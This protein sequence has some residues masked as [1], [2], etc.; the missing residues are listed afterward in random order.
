MFKCTEE[1]AN[2]IVRIRKLLRCY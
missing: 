1:E 2:F